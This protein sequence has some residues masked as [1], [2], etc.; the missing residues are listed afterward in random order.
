[1]RI[2]KKILSGIVIMALALI[3][4]GQLGSLATEKAAGIELSLE[5]A[6]ELALKSSSAVEVAKLDVGKAKL[7]VPAQARSEL[8]LAEEKLKQAEAVLLDAENNEKTALMKVEA[9]RKRSSVQLL[10]SGGLYI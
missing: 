9:N 1:M 10:R 3:I 6:Y 5:Q 4:P 7:V 8:F 2:I